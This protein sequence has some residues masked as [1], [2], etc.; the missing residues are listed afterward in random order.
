MT[1][2]A[3]AV[4]A[5]GLGTLAV[6]VAAPPSA[7][8]RRRRLLS[9][10]VGTTTIDPGRVAVVCVPVL[11][12]VLL[13]PLGAL[14]GVAAAPVVRRQVAA[15]ASV[16]E[17]R[18]AEAMVAQAP[19][20]LDLVAAVLAAG[21]SP[22]SAV[23]VV[24]EHTPAPLGVVL[25]DLGRRLRLSTDPVSAWLTL[26]G[27]A[28]EA[29]GRALARSQNSGAAIVPVVADTADDVRR[30]ARALRRE[31]AGRVAVR[32]TVPLGLCLLPAFVLIGVA[33]TVLAVVTA[34]TR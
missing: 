33:P 30:R 17:Q 20:T 32:T 3:A 9:A 26:D 23:S 27:T 10:G 29:V 4:V 11:A 2:A 7:R 25:G 13:G 34:A 16:R 22:E 1:P 8:R 12:F 24:A 28:L 19:V 5:A 6:L 21:R 31:A 15:L 14:V 18:R